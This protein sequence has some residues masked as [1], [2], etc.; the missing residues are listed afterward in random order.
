MTG[1]KSRG[2]ELSVPQPQHWSRLFPELPRDVLRT[3]SLAGQIETEIQMLKD[4]RASGVKASGASGDL[5]Q[6]IDSEDASLATL[7]K[8]MRSQRATIDELTQANAAL[9]AK[10]LAQ[11]FGAVDAPAGMFDNVNPARAPDGTIWS[12]PHSTV[13]DGVDWLCFDAGLLRFAATAD[14]LVEK[15][16]EQIHGVDLLVSDIRSGSSHDLLFGIRGVGRS[17][18]VIWLKHCEKIVARC[19]VTLGFSGTLPV[20]ADTT[21]FDTPKAWVYFNRSGWSIIRIQIQAFSDLSELVLRVNARPERGST[22][23]YEGTPPRGL[24]VSRLLQMGRA[25]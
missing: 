20:S 10:V 8:A 3:A 12:N 6:P 7:L 18:C 4:A 15:K 25:R 17:E 11:A 22:T 2:I 24:I 1:P 19:P 16:R 23:R 9:N 13:R 14:R 21:T 5:A